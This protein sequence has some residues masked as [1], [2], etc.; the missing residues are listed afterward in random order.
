MPLTPA[1]WSALRKAGRLCH[2][3]AEYQGEGKN[4]RGAY[5]CGRRHPPMYEDCLRKAQSTAMEKTATGL[6]RWMLTH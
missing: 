6:G 4:Q 5:L 1:L 3:L 2:T